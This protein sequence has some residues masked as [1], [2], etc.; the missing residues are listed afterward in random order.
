MTDQELFDYIKNNLRITIDSSSEW[1]YGTENHYVK[2]V[3]YP[4][5]FLLPFVLQD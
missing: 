4:K 2:V 1:D 3:C 5:I